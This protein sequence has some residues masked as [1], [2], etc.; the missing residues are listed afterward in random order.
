VSSTGTNYSTIFLKVT[1]HL[2]NIKGNI[3]LVALPFSFKLS[4]ILKWLIALHSS[5]EEL[6]RHNYALV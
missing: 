3:F 6:L 1:L 4:A 5:K 2:A